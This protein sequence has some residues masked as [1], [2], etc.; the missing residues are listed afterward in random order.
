MKNPEIFDRIS[1]ITS[2]LNSERRRFSAF[3]IGNTSV[4][5]I[6]PKSVISSNFFLHLLQ[7][8]LVLFII[9]TVSILGFRCGE[10]PTVSETGSSMEIIV[11]LDGNLV[12]EDGTPAAG[13]A[14]YLR[15]SDYLPATSAKV[16]AQFALKSLDSTVT[17][18]LGNFGFDSIAPGT[19]TLEC[20][21]GE[22]GNGALIESVTVVDPDSSVELATDT[23]KPLGSIAG[24]IQLPESLDASQ[25]RVLVYGLNRVVIPDSL[26]DYAISGLA[27][28]EYSFRL[29]ILGGQGVDLDSVAIVSDSTTRPPKMI[30]P[31]ADKIVARNAS[32]AIT[33]D[34]VLDE[35]SWNSTHK[36]AFSGPGVSEN[37]VK[38]HA[39]WDS[40]NLYIAYE[41]TDTLISVDPD[42]QDDAS[43]DDGAE[44][45]L[46]LNH[47]ASAA[48]DGDDVYLLANVIDESKVLRNEQYLAST[49]STK[50]HRT[51]E[52]YSM[53]IAIPWTLVNLVPSAGLN[54]GI[55]FV[56]NDKDGAIR[57][58]FDWL[59]L[60]SFNFKK[61][62]LWGDLVL[63]P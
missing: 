53:E 43:Q 51:A 28:G 12:N 57:Y 23:L 5:G 22:A 60:T 26:G 40:A 52:G 35:S 15:P 20:L 58:Q 18:S 29:Q 34:G 38:V 36:I 41:V 59:G 33:I 24:Q 8:P 14:V 17:D 3:R 55:L 27:E 48:M 39:L 7:S 56:N 21:D 30:L 62:N 50:T 61:P 19:Y 1:R 44:I 47:D 42:T 4:F 46:D 63:L 37:L 2:I 25:I 10:N 16:A 9:A 54:L 13:A 49:V 31:G 11:S 45:Y 6:P 32:G